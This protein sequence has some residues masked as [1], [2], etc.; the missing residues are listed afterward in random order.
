MDADC[1]ARLASLGATP[2]EQQLVAELGHELRPALLRKAYI[3]AQSAA[4]QLLSA[5]EAAAS[6]CVSFFLTAPDGSVAA[7]ATAPTLSVP[8][9]GSATAKA[10]LSVSSPRLWSSWR[11]QPA[12]Q[13]VRKV[14]GVVGA[15]PLVGRIERD[16]CDRLMRDNEGGAA[17][18]SFTRTKPISGSQAVNTY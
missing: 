15:A 10:A 8:V 6:V 2:Q 14:I 17:L 11:Y 12:D 13:V 3:G 5:E 7:T 9:G 18:F 4:R 1:V 16:E